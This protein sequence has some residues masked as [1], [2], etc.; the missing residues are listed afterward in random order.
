[1]GDSKF[2]NLFDFK[3]WEMKDEGFYLIQKLISFKVLLKKK[4]CIR[5][6]QIKLTRDNTAIDKVKWVF[7][8]KY[9]P[10]VLKVKI[11]NYKTTNNLDH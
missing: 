7:R 9:K 10:T 8:E 5:G 2:L 6:R 4:K 1:M 3:E 11:C